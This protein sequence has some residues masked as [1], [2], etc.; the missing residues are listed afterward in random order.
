MRF[1]PVKKCEGMLRDGIRE[2]GRG[3]KLEREAEIE[4]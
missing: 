4:R 2:R 3:R 1:F